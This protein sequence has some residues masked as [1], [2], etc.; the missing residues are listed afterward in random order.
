[1]VKNHYTPLL[2][3]QNPFN[4]ESLIGR[5]DTFI[6]GHMP[7]KAA[8]DIALHD[9]KGKLLQVP[10]YHLLG[11]LA[12]DKVQLIA[13]QI[14]R[15]GAKEQ[16]VEAAGHVEQGFKVIKVK[17]GGSDIEEDLLRIQEVRNAVGNSISIRV[18]ANQFYD[19]FS[20]GKLIK[21]LQPY[22]VEWVEDPIP[23][24]DL[25]GFTRVHAQTD[26]PIEAGQLGTASDMLRLIRMNAVDCFKVKVHRGGGLLKTKQCVALA[27]AANMPMVSGSNG[28]NDILFAA[29]VALNASSRHMSLACESTGSWSGYADEFRFIKEPL[30]VKNGYVDVSD[31]PGLGVELIDVDN[32]DSLAERFSTVK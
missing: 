10:V 30:K 7:S 6:S 9:L 23:A 18:D 12:R 1:M 13:P 32:L 19:G 14:Q 3:N 28:D 20:A 8:I 29:E 11:G 26:I 24:W 31:K 4:I 2:L 25:E 27:E 22:E 21:R 16:A 15:S 17:I 5:L